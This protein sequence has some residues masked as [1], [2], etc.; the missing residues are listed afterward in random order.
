MSESVVADFVGTFNS[1]ASVRQ[2]PVKGRILLSE[3][4]LVL[5]ADEGKVTIPLSSIFD[6]SVGTVPDDLGDFFNATVT[7]AFERN[8]RR[9]VAAIEA[10]D[11]KIEKFTT[12]LFKAILNG[13]DMTVKHPARVGGRVAGESFEPAKLFLKPQA[14]EFT[15]ADGSVGVD[16][17]TVIDFDRLTREVN[18]ADQPVLAVKHTPSGRTLTTLAATQSSRKMSILGRYLRREY[19][20]LMADLE[21]VSLSETE[22]E[23]L[24][25]IYSSGPGVSLASV[26]SGEASQATMVL[27]DLRS[28]G[29]VVDGEGGPQLTPTGQVVV[30]KYL[31]RVNE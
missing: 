5:A 29:L 9:M 8:D 6:V 10:D 4:R 25:A 1:E 18:G 2:E 11:E 20:D 21:D 22:V 15:L 26:V 28:D 12:V 17:A 13:T 19:S 16:L 14:V 27:N 24:I 31:E 3:R 7:V 30:S 23:I